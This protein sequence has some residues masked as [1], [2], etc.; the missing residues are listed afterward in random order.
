HSYSDISGIKTESSNGLND[1]WI[2]KLNE[3]APCDNPPA[4][5]YADFI[6]ATTAKLH[7]SADPDAIK[8]KIQYRKSTVTTWTNTS[9]TSNVKNLFS[10]EPSTT[11]KYRVKT[12]CGAGVLSEWS[13]VATFT[14]LPLREGEEPGFSDDMLLS[15]YPNPS[16]GNFT[17]KFDD[18]LQDQPLSI[19][20]KNL[21]GEEVFHQQITASDEHHIQLDKNIAN[22]M[23]V[24]EVASGEKMVT[25][26]IIVSK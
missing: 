21:L 26:Q 11:Y 22:G 5:L 25:Q 16:S 12:N 6:T 3:V 9:A 8:Y 18:V 7:W 4:D 23:Y 20:I 14:T 17:L 24:I 19:S 10:L 2:L 1:Y 15:V 13:S